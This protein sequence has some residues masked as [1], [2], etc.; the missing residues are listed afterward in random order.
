MMQIKQDGNH[1]WFLPHR[2]TFGTSLQSMSSTYKF[3]FD[4]AIRDGYENAA[5]MR[6]D[7]GIMGLMW[8]RYYPVAA[9]DWT[10]E[11]EGPD[12]SEEINR[13]YTAA[14]EQI[15]YWW[16]FRWSMLE[17]V[18][19]GRY[20][21]QFVTDW[22]SSDGRWFAY[23]DKPLYTI[24]DWMP[25]LGDKITF[26]WSGKPA[27]RVSPMYAP[28]WKARGATV[29]EPNDKQIAWDSVKTRWSE[30]GP[31]LLIDQPWIREMF[32]ITTFIR[33]D[34]P[35]DQGDLAGGV[36][37]V[38]IRHYAYW[39]WW[40]RN[41]LIGWALNHLQDFGA[42]GYTVVGYDAANPA[43][44]D[45]AKEAFAKP[46][47]RVIFV[48]YSPNLNE[49]IV[50]QITRLSPQGE[51]NKALK[52]W[53]E[54]YFDNKLKILIIQQQLSSES[55]AS[56]LGSGNAELQGGVKQ[57][58]HKQD[59]LMIDTEMS[60][61]VLPII[62]KA[63]DPTLRFKLKFKSILEKP[64][65][66]HL[67]KNLET[68]K[69]WN[70]PVGKGWLYKVLDIPE[71]DPEEDELV[72]P[73]GQQ[74]GL[75]DPM[76]QG[77]GLLPGQPPGA[78]G[79]AA[80]D[81]GE[82]QG[83]EEHTLD[84][85]RAE[86]ERQGIP[87]EEQLAA[88]AAMVE[89]GTLDE[90]DTPEGLVYTGDISPRGKEEAEPEETEG[91]GERTTYAQER[92]EWMEGIGPRSG[93]PRWTNSLTGRV[94]YTAPSAGKQAQGT[95]KG[96]N[97]GKTLSEADRGEDRALL[98][99]KGVAVQGV[100]EQYNR[101]A[102]EGGKSLA[103]E[104]VVQ[105]T[106]HLDKRLNKA[107]VM[108]LAGKHGGKGFKSKTAAL[109]YLEGKLRE[110]QPAVELKGE[111]PAAGEAM[112][113]QIGQAG[114]VPVA[115]LQ[116]DPKRFQY[117][118]GP[119]HNAKGVGDELQGAK[120]DPNYAGAILTWQDPDNSQDYV[121][122][123]HHRFDLA[124]SSGVD[125]INRIPIQAKDAAEARTIG[126]LANIA[127]GKGTAT[128]AAK[129]FRDSGMSREQA[130]A[131]GV[132]D[133]QRLLDQGMQL[134]KLDDGIFER[135]T[136]GTVSEGRAMALAHGAGENKVAQ[137]AA[138]DAINAAEAKG[139]TVTDGQAFYLAQEAGAA[140]TVKT[141]EQDL[142]GG[143]EE[144]KS[145]HL[146][147]AALK[148]YVAGELAK[149]KN[150]FGAVSSTKR[151][152]MLGQAGNVIKPEDNA[153]RA[154]EADS[155]LQRFRNTASLKGEL[156][157]MLSS[158]AEKL[159]ASPKDAGKIRIETAEAARNILQ[160]EL[161][162]SNMATPSGEGERNDSALIGS[163][164]S[165]LSKEA[166]PPAVSM[167]ETGGT[168]SVLLA[169]S[170]GPVRMSSPLS[171]IEKFKG[172]QVML[173]DG[174]LMHVRQ[175]EDGSYT[176][177]GVSMNPMDADQFLSQNKA[178]ATPDLF[179]DGGGNDAPAPG[180]GNTGGSSGI[181]SVATDAM[182]Q[183][184]AGR[185]GIPAE[186]VKD[187]L[188]TDRA[189]LQR[190]DASYNPPSNN[191]EKPYTDYEQYPL[192]SA[193]VASWNTDHNEAYVDYLTEH[194]PAD[195][196]TSEHEDGIR[197]RDSSYPKY[198]EWAKAGH[199]APPIA[200]ARAAKPDAKTVSSNR[201]RVLAA[202]EAGVAKLKAWH[203]PENSETGNPLKYGDVIR[204]AEEYKSKGSQAKQE[205]AAAMFQ[206]AMNPAKQPAL[207]GMD[208][209][210]IPE[211]A[212]SQGGLFDQKPAS[213][214]PRGKE[215]HV[216]G[217]EVFKAD[218]PMSGWPESGTMAQLEAHARKKYGDNFA[219]IGV[220]HYG[221]GSQV[222]IKRKDANRG[223]VMMMAYPLSPEQ[224]LAF[225]KKHIDNLLKADSY[226]SQKT[227]IDRLVNFENDEGRQALNEF[228]ENHPRRHQE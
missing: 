10:I 138:F 169:E 211:S 63:N 101:L 133:K 155:L 9:A 99:G 192:G 214:S 157:T 216:T 110:K 127:E 203:S 88:L 146:E 181:T 115:S 150:A 126:A 130:V 205:R 104:G 5:A 120:Y 176:L 175:G 66:D 166:I 140:S 170:S 1:V 177:G 78:G 42:G 194:N 173:E 124:K 159:A 73:P 105:M 23:D 121:V 67:R 17:A 186:A 25:H 147:R 92:G 4:E 38:G 74:G 198:V 151:A 195:L 223:K 59:A 162:V 143:F 22:R 212:D 61:S 131:A 30:M 189:E 44:R 227:R 95:E 100:L 132:P 200:T 199:E 34:S 141:Q 82:G 196:V 112:K 113:P 136:M 12:A 93:K 182:H 85:A 206:E 56:G 123:G 103:G 37:G 102:T 179:D 107:Q 36:Y 79:G 90:H 11:S 129:I 122:N 134:S 117:K 65:A 18:W 47:N 24:S 55:E 48:P 191:A 215:E 96:E 207:P 208:D 168:G 69:N 28:W 219:G 154:G 97:T 94:R 226:D 29:L 46:Q 87:K 222:E 40:M 45:K 7:A 218:K 202:Q 119:S 27:I 188:N 180:A 32:S 125:S 139:K 33:Q 145:T 71:P 160:K 161:Q 158:Q 89:A 76:G 21:L 220:S 165:S 68:A 83:G 52:D 109:A 149:V 70:I 49:R 64:D 167:P 84:T 39:T 183:H 77:A 43:S 80:G 20:G 98:P 26:T 114:H 128:D 116:V 184:I 60:Q 224:Q 172:R 171:T 91:E 50:D 174:R 13:K 142:F 53:A 72:Y 16:N 35:W 153:A 41:E 193:K 111:K 201:R 210:T 185:F 228:I 75:D 58:V 221:G 14:V 135:L 163:G 54:G 209:A 15:P 225:K 6:N 137:R 187:I 118:I 178:Q 19:Y 213:G 204:A 108:E 190:R 62:K 31:V 152:D 144:E 2:D 51:G 3:S 81:T 148:S 197:Q 164:Q 57:L 8:Q 217:G 156:A 106:G 86:L